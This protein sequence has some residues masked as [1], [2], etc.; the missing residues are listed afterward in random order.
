[1]NNF[2]VIDNAGNVAASFAKTQILRLSLL[3]RQKSVGLQS[4]VIC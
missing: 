3:L 2:V 1:M 4:I